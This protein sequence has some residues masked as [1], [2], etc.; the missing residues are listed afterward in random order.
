M[1]PNFNSFNS[2]FF[3]YHPP[4]LLFNLLLVWLTNVFHNSTNKLTNLVFSNS[5]KT[6]RF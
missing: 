1:S 5:L 3:T 2:N 4:D 6:S